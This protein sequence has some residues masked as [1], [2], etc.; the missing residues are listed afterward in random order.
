MLNVVNVRTV[1]WVSKRVGNYSL[2]M[3]YQNI[4]PNANPIKACTGWIIEYNNIQKNNL[5]PSIMD[6]TPPMK[7][8]ITN[9]VI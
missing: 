6:V 5:I 8:S 4:A 9:T 7:A 3:A 2:V 1:P